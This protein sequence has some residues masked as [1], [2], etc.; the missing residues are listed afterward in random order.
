VDAQR[1]ILLQ[2]GCEM[3]QG[4]LYARPMLPDEVP[5]WL[6][7]ALQ[8]SR[9]AAAASGALAAQ[10]RPRSTGEMVPISA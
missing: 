8:L 1:A 9:A 2:L 5:G 7:D 6:A 10:R 4:Y 3:G